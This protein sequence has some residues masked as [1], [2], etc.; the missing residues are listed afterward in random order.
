MLL[1]DWNYTNAQSFE[2]M[3]GVERVFVDVQYLKHFDVNK[4]ISL[5]TRTRATAEYSEH[6]TNLFTG[7]YLNYTNKFGFGGSVIG[8]VSSTGAGIDAG[9]HYF[10][11]SKT[12]VIYALPS[13]NINNELLYSWFSIIRYTPTINQDWK[14]YTSLELFSAFGEIGHLNSIER[15]RFGVNKKGYK[16]G[17]AINLNQSR[18]SDTD[19][20]SGVFIRKQFLIKKHEISIYRNWQCGLCTC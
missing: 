7:A 19:I 17:L 18:F 8:R 12:F 20:N 1:F 4:K 2:L 10:K 16:F 6:N 9:V 11:A 13:I 14:L 15:I 3:S 5:F